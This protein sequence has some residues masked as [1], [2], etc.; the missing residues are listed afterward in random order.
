MS[1]RMRL[2]VSQ[3]VL[4]HA[5]Q[6][7]AQSLVSLLRPSYSEDCGPC[8]YLRLMGVPLSC[9]HLRCLSR[10]SRLPWQFRH[11]IQ[12]KTERE[13]SRILAYGVL[14]ASILD[15]AHNV[16]RTYDHRIDLFYIARK[17]WHDVS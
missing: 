1:S 11:Y 10:P 12:P 14:Y 5:Y 17:R 15:L 16:L 4:R 8:G 2:R 7:V 3:P 9:S 13:R 6:Q